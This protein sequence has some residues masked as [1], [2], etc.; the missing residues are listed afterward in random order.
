MNIFTF[1][2]NI[3]EK[4]AVAIDETLEVVVVSARTTRK[5][6]SI[7]EISVDQMVAEQQAELDAI[8]AIPKTS[9]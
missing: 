3:L 8:L 7:A 2:G 9:T 4:S 5:A 6:V 1:I